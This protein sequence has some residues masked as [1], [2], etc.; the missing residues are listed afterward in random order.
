MERHAAPAVSN[1]TMVEL[2]GAVQMLESFRKG[3][4]SGEAAIRLEQCTS[5]T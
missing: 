5:V 1:Y 2:D 4:P 3:G